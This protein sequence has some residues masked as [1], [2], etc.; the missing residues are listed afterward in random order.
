MP[1][2][3]F[4][5]CCHPYL[6]PQRDLCSNPITIDADPE[7]LLAQGVD[8]EQ[9]SLMDVIQAQEQDE[10]ESIMGLWRYY[11]NKIREPLQISHFGHL[12]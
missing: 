3:A 8:G 7:D 11:I 10:E 12:F 4:F 6:R 9:M 5:P 2:E 1:G